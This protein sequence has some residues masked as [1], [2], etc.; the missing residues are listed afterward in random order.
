[1]H[2]SAA[3]FGF[4][5]ACIFSLALTPLVRLLA[6][7]RQL[8][9]LP[10]P[11]KIHRV[12]RPLVG[13]L[14][15]YAALALSLLATAYAFPHLEESFRAL[16]RAVVVAGGLVVVLGLIDDLQGSRPWK[17]LLTQA[18]AVGVVQVHVDV[19]GLGW[20][21]SA[22]P[23]PMLVAI[24]LV[25]P[26]VVGVTN[27]MNLIDGLDGLA[28]GVAAASGLGLLALGWALG[29]PV[30]AVVAA[31]VVGAA[32]GF[33]RSNAH[34]AKIFMGDTGSMFLGFVLAIL[35]ARLFHSR[36]QPL[37]LLAL[38]LILW[39]PCIDA[40]YAVLRR[41]AGRR[42]IFRPDRGHIHHRLLDAGL[43][44]RSAGLALCCLSAL[45]ALA[46]VQVGRGQSPLPWTGSVLL[47][48]LPLAIV[49][50]TRRA[51]PA[52]APGAALGATL[53]PAAAAR[54]AGAAVRTA[55]AGR[56]AGSPVRVPGATPPAD[57]QALEP[58]ALAPQAVSQDRAA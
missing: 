52:L 34:P 28:S 50:R 30:P 40:V 21:T 47:A 37:T 54:V 44:Q 3:V 41:W 2:V 4:S 13:G 49:L 42:S 10:G 25:V 24:A 31:V 33:L 45:G 27:A 6:V 8:Q 9:D 26:W 51:Q 46:G 48:T 14:A 29:Q 58:A 32:L 23:L 57:Q 36:P 53:G 5:L 55:S 15:I 56:T 19:L 22:G 11:H 7:R 17:K 38:I 16:A 12:A 1:L 43:S 39:V 20:T 35:G 18:L